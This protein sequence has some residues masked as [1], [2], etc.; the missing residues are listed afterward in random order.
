MG[1]DVG[2]TNCRQQ[3]D[4]RRP[5]CTKLSK[6]RSH[7]RELGG[8]GVLLSQDVSLTPSKRSYNHRMPG[9]LISHYNASGILLR[10][11]S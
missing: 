1:G 2:R 6:G 10:T 3:D 5:L 7:N 9:A 11:A 8:V 4:Q